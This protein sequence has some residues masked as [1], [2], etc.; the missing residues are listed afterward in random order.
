MNREMISHLPIFMV[1]TF[2]IRLYLV[3]LLAIREE[4]INAVSGIASTI[5]MLD[6]MPLIV[7]SDTKAVENR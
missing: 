6:E 7:S 5:P 3:F 4:D 1:V 2:G